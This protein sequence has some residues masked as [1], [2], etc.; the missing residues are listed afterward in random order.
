MSACER[1]RARDTSFDAV[2]NSPDF[3]VEVSSFP[4]GGDTAFLRIAV[5]LRVFA[6]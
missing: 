5:F 4:N 1:E 3:S 6:F 2:S